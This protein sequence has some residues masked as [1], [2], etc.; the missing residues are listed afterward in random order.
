MSTETLH[1]VFFTI[2]IW[3]RWWWISLYRL[4]TLGFFFVRC[5]R[6]NWK[7]W[8]S[9]R[10]CVVRTYIILKTLPLF[11]RHAPNEGRTLRWS[12]QKNF[13]HSFFI[14]LF[15]LGLRFKEGVLSDDVLKCIAKALAQE[16]VE[17]VTR[18]FCILMD[19]PYN[20][21]LKELLEEQ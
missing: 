15:S 10:R 13:F 20:D 5:Y 1:F 7:R 14:C 4:L 21:V 11:E 9:G 6:W 3:N 2:R 16:K 19:R 18:F 12:V 8:F 17:K